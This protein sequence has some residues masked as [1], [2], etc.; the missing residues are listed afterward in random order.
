M[1]KV[2]DLVA[3]VP[4]AGLGTRS[5]PATSAI[6]KEMLPIVDVPAIQL[7]VEEAAACGV[8]HVVLVTARGKHAI[9]DHFDLSA[10]VED[11][12]KRQNKTELLAELQRLSSFVSLV[13]VRQKQPLGL[14]HAVLCAA[15]AVGNR[16]IVVMLPDDLIDAE[17]PATLGLY[18]VYRRTGK[19]CI[20][21]MEVEPG[22]E[23]M[24]GIVKGKQ[25][26]PRLWSLEDLIEKPEPNEAPSRMA[27]VARYVLPP[28]IFSVLERVKPGRGGEIQL[29]DALAMLAREQG[30]WG[31][32]LEGTRY[33]IGDKLG[34]IQ[35]NVAY[36]MKRPALAEPL[37]AYLKGLLA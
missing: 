1:F 20:G 12:L 22:H 29:T 14:G 23:R 13:S 10:E 30:L 21:L 19:G 7:I 37:K 15:E 31:L 24:Y 4:A 11:A 8:K 36:A 35:A 2:S 25:V 27:V 6:P 32:A 34:Y 26:E 17:R 5:L 16:P 3:V 18:D 33:D 28:S 9:E